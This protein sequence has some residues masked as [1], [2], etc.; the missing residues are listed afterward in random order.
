[1]S[2]L[3]LPW[4]L[5]SAPYLERS[6]LISTGSDNYTGFRPLPWLPH[7]KQPILQRLTLLCTFD[8]TL[9][10]WVFKSYETLS[11]SLLLGSCIYR[12]LVLILL[13]TFS[14]LQHHKFKGRSPMTMMIGAL[15][16]WW[17]PDDYKH[18]IC[19]Q[20]LTAKQKD[21]STHLNHQNRVSVINTRQAVKTENSSQTCLLHTKHFKQIENYE[22]MIH[23]SFGS[24]CWCITQLSSLPHREIN[25][26]EAA[27][28]ELPG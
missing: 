19:I 7:H 4:I 13:I 22:G 2:E 25:C 16:A 11:A 27:L 5:L 26:G 8:F 21:S 24:S 1:M 12:R 18:V 6:A 23:C 9:I 15:T 17:L 28:H 3:F 14:S 10:R 20:Q